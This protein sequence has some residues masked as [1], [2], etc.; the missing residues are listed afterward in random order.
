MFED[1]A[2][3]GISH[4]HYS[5]CSDTLTNGSETLGLTRSTTF[6]SEFVY[7]FAFCV[8]TDCL[9]HSE[10]TANHEIKKVLP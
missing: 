4:Y 7:H 1:P 8:Y 9:R 3:G 10:C 2:V 5:N 6:C